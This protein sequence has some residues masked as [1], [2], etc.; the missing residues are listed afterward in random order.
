MKPNPSNQVK[1]RRPRSKQVLVILLNHLQTLELIREEIH[2][3]VG[4][5][6]KE[7]FELAVV[8]WNGLEVYVPVECVVFLADQPYAKRGIEWGRRFLAASSR[9][10][11]PPR[12][13]RT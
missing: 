9:Y 6:E 11:N 13:D 12:G 4:D 5:F 8:R 3:A 1:V 2:P 7:P 10:R